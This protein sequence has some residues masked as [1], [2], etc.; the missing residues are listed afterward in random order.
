MKEVEKKEEGMIFI[1][2]DKNPT[3]MGRKWMKWRRKKKKK[4]KIRR[5]REKKRKRKN[6]RILVCYL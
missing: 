6:S 4:K 5:K 3:E 1:R 2:I